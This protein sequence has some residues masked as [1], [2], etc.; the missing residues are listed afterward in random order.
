MDLRDR[1]L[2]YLRLPLR[3]SQQLVLGEDMF[4][5]LSYSF[6]IFLYCSCALSNDKP[7]GSDLDSSEHLETSSMLFKTILSQ[8]LEEV[9]IMTFPYISIFQIVP[10]GAFF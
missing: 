1:A 3:T 7:L 5:W 8:D 9:V 6:D 10:I 4:P 2:L